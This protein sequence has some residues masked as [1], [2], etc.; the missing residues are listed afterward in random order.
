MAFAL[1]AAYDLGW[2]LSCNAYVTLER[3]AWI[4][5]AL[6]LAGA[7]V[8]SILGLRKNADPSERARMTRARWAVYS[9][10]L[11]LIAAGFIAGLGK[12]SSLNQRGQLGA[13]TLALTFVSL[14]C[15]LA[16]KYF[17]LMYALT[18]YRLFIFYEKP[19]KAAETK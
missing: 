18:I 16:Y 7:I 6:G 12:V 17:T 19:D 1:G 13:I 9:V 8:V 4:L 2:A 14:S 3:L 10:M 15:L 11:A 5:V